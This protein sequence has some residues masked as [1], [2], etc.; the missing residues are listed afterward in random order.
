[1]VVIQWEPIRFDLCVHQRIQVGQ[2]KLL[3]A[4]K[5]KLLTFSAGSSYKSAVDQSSADCAS[6][7]VKILNYKPNCRFCLVDNPRTVYKATQSR[8]LVPYPFLSLSTQLQ[9]QAPR[10]VV[11]AS[12]KLNAYYLAGC[13]RSN[14]SARVSIFSSKFWSGRSNPIKYFC[15]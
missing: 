1:M 8:Y 15:K 4:T 3:F 14:F 12:M 6:A 10:T 13:A 5:I 7:A 2:G 9:A 11:K